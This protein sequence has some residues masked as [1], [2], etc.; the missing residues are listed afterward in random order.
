MNLI[1]LIVQLISGAVAGNT[2][3]AVSKS[4]SLGPVGDSI[5]GALGGGVGGQILSSVLGMGGAAGVFGVDATRR[6]ARKR[7][8]G[9]LARDLTR[10]GVERGR[11]PVVSEVDDGAGEGAGDALDHLHPAHDHLAELVHGAGLGAGDDVVG[12]GHVV[13]GDDAVDVAEYRC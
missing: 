11:A 10:L 4:T 3:G 12:A 6:R 13:G 1:A 5:V 8:V 2:A 9:A 7:D